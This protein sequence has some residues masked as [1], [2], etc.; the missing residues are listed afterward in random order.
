MKVGG[1]GGAEP[2]HYENIPT[3]KYSDFSFHIKNENIS[4]KVMIFPLFL[5][6]T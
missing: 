4:G 1:G 6:K 2:V 5:L 3:Q